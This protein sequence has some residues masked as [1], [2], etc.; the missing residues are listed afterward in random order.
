MRVTCCSTDSK[1]RSTL[2]R[3]ASAHGI[4]IVYQELLS[5][6]NLNISDNIFAGRELCHAQLLIDRPAEDT[7]ANTVLRRLRK[8]P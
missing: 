1:S 3:D 7:R 4:S 5:L 6:T 2:P 8:L